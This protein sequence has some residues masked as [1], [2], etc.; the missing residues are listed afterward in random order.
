MSTPRSG[1]REDTRD[2]LIPVCPS[3]GR[4]ILGGM[5]YDP[6]RKAIAEFLGTF[7]LVFAVSMSVAV[8]G[9]VA[10]IFG[11]AI[12]QGLALGIMVSALGTSRA[13]TSIPPSRSAPS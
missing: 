8:G 12:A 5:E 4:S 1:H 9:Q 11:A 13:R 2:D 10:G 7:T 3:A 6:A